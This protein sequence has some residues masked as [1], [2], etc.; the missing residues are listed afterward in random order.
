MKS[1]CMLRPFHWVIV[2]MKPTIVC[3][4]LC[5]NYVSIAKWISYFCWFADYGYIDCYMTKLASLIHTLPHLN[6]VFLYV[7][8]QFGVLVYINCKINF[9]FMEF[10]MGETPRGCY[11]SLSASQMGLPNV[12]RDSFRFETARICHSL[13]LRTLFA[14]EYKEKQCTIVL[15]RPSFLSFT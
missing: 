14:S 5:L 10:R 3:H 7:I 12:P 6:Q 13:P 4:C 8:C 2:V 11:I 9:T 1:T 15:G